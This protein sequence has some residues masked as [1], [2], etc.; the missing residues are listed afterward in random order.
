MILENVNLSKRNTAF[1]TKSAEDRGNYRGRYA[2]Y[3]IKMG[4]IIALLLNKSMNLIIKLTKN[5]QGVLLGN[6]TFRNSDLIDTKA[7]K[8]RKYCAKLSE[9]RITHLISY[10]TNQIQTDHNHRLRLN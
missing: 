5:K 7:R 8:S 2:S 6:N 9:N 3:L 10:H 4:L 1:I